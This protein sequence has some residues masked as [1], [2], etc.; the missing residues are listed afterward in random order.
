MRFSNTSAQINPIQKKMKDIITLGVECDRNL[1]TAKQFIENRLDI[2][3]KENDNVIK[4]NTVELVEDHKDKN[5]DIYKI[6]I[7]EMRSK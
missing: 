2:E 6:A 7:S 3:I 5:G 4:S 1:N